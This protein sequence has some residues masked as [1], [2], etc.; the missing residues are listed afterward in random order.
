MTALETTDPVPVDPDHAGAE[1]PPP[2][3][4]PGAGEPVVWDG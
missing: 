1:T 2:G 4:L 3:R